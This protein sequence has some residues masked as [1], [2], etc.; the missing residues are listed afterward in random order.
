MLEVR[1]LQVHFPVTRGIFRRPIGW[2]RA[3]D[4]VRFAIRRGE[5]FG[6]VGESG[7]GKS[8]TGRAI[9]HLQP[10]TA[11]EV[12]F[13]GIN[14]TR[15]RGTS[16]RKARRRMQLIFQDPY[17]SLN[18]RMKVGEI[19]AEPVHIHRL[20]DGRAAVRERVQ[21]L[22]LLVGLSPTHADRYPHALSGGQRQRVAI[23][24]ALAAE[25]L[26]LVCDEPVSNLDART[27]AQ[28]LTVLQTLQAQ[29]DLSL[30]F[31]SHDLSVIHVLCHR[32]GVMYLGK[33]VEVADRT[34]LFQTPRHPYTWALRSA[35]PIP[36]PRVE[37]HRKPLVL[38]GDIPH[39]LHPP[40]GCRF[41]TRC[42]LA[43]KQCGEE[44]PPL[45]PMASHSEHL[46]ACWRAEEVPRLMT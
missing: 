13:Q 39:P 4:G 27:Q 34:T 11:G 6:L 1:D 22:L 30:L 40:P 20:R 28:I 36:D 45:A 7:C 29:L 46:V 37:R 43:V 18:P 42:P 9:L 15:L 41:H 3:V 25:P 12:I 32:V 2:I 26:F 35:I 44:E 14:V 38:P 24:R 21:E 31:I 16:L 10:P 33:L 8:T 19:I 17:A 23:A 5:A